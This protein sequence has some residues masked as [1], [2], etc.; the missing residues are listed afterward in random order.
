MLPP[1]K[2]VK[3]VNSSLADVRRKRQDAADDIRKK[4]KDDQM[5]KRRFMDESDDESETAPNTTGKQRVQADVGMLE[6]Y[7]MEVMNSQDYATVFNAAH[8]L[9]KIVSKERNPPI[10]RLIDT[11]VVPF[12]LLHLKQFDNPDLQFESSWTLTNIASGTAQHTELVVRLG[13]IAVFSQ[14]LSSH[15]ERVVEQGMWALG[16]IAGENANY[17][18]LVL[19]HGVLAGVLNKLSGTSNQSLLANGTWVISNLCRGK[20]PAPDFAII[21]DAIPALAAVLN[22]TDSVGALTDACWAFS[23]I[24]D[25][26]EEQIAAVIESGAVQRLVELLQH[27]DTN[28]QTPAM[29]ALG[30]IVTGTTAQTQTVLDCGFLSV[31]G[32]LLRSVKENIRKEACWCLSN[33]LA[34]TASQVA[35]VIDANLLPLVLNAVSLGEA[36]TRKEAS[37]C[38]INLLTG[39]SDQQVRFAIGQGCIPPLCEVLSHSDAKLVTSALEAHLRILK[40]GQFANGSNPHAEF[41]ETA[42]GMDKIEKLQHHRNDTIYKLANQ[43]VTEYFS[44]DSTPE[45]A[46]DQNM[47]P[48]A[49]QTGFTF[50]TEPAK[51]FAFQAPGQASHAQRMFA[52]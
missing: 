49:T 9:R 28:I 52:F 30:N 7:A 26:D 24:A 4:S 10:D 23:Y 41:I 47:M 19:R 20:N 36:R 33:I 3:D 42:G 22:F 29:R 2:N 13:G 40:L 48:T 15:D 51:S 6:Q 37:W 21:R 18:D 31:V 17:R 14:L 5:L 16:N 43:I 12:L 39:G 35:Q 8:C 44:D 46:E 45:D 50:S 32:T 34:G 27:P 38:I 25:S 1:R 11:G